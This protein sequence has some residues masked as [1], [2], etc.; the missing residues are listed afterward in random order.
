[1]LA[2][3]ILETQLIQRAYDGCW[4]KVVK[5]MDRENAYSYQNESGAKVTLIPE[6]WVTIGVY[7]FIM[8]E[9]GA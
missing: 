4:E 6:K 5:I 1:M 2:S 7:D 3:D 8:E 9:V